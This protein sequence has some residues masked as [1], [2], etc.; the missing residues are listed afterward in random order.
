MI[1]HLL[2]LLWNRRKTYTVLIFEQM[3]VFIAVA[4]SLTIVYDTVRGFNTPGRIDPDNIVCFGYMITGDFDWKKSEQSIHTMDVVKEKLGK[5]PYVVGISESYYFIPYMRPSDYYWADSLI[6]TPEKKFFVHI[7]AT[8]ETAEKVFNPKIVQGRWFRNGE[9]IDGKYPAVLSE[10]LVMDMDLVNPVGKTISLGTIP[11]II[12]GVVSGIKEVP[13]EEAP[14]SIIVPIDLM[15]PTGSSGT[16]EELAAKLQP[17]YEEEFANDFYKEFNRIWDGNVDAEC[18]IYPLSIG[19]DTYMENNV[20]SMAAT[21][22]PA[23]FFLLFTIIGT[24]GINLTGTKERMKEFALRIA[25]GASRIRAMSL[26]IMQNIIVTGTSAIPGIAVI[27]SIYPVEIS[28]PVV[29]FT[30]ILTLLISFLCALYPAFIILRMNPAELL[31][32]E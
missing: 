25:C 17:G 26:V 11:C 3:L 6:F 15:L 14:P 7:K 29:V 2:I 5:K 16:F 19:H 13:L 32:E 30:L 31:K 21:G 18:I 1:K 9:R 22:I 27:L 10:Q 8:D 24:V 23:V 28:L 12:T 4:L 20:I